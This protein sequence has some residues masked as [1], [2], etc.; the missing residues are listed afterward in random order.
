MTDADREY[1]EALADMSEQIGLR[2]NSDC[3]NCFQRKLCEAVTGMKDYVEG[4]VEDE[5]NTAGSH[6]TA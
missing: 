1:F 3:D 4:M 2:C 6:G 5:Q